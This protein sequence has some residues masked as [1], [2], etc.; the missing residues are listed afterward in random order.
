LE[1]AS[2]VRRSKSPWTSLL[3]MVPQKDGSWR[4]CGDYHHLNL[5]TSPGVVPLAK[6][7]RPFKRLAW[8]L[9]FFKNQP[10]QGLSPILCCS[11]RHPKNGDYYTIW[12][13]CI[14]VHTIWAV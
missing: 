10:C 5:V 14:F 2:I 1:S 13:V 6:H 11:R 3:H 4:H 12:L 7:A 9:R 8:L